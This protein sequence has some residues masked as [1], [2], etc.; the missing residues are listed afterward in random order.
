MGPHV[1]S[2]DDCPKPRTRGTHTPCPTHPQVLNVDGCI[3]ALFL[4]LLASSGC[5][6][7]KESAEIVQIGCGRPRRAG[8][9]AGAAA[10]RVAVRRACSHEWP[11]T[12][13]ACRAARGVRARL[14]LSAFPRPRRTTPSCVYR[15]CLSAIC[16]AGLQAASLVWPVVGTLTRF[17]W[18]RGPLGWWGMRWTR[19]ACSSRSTGTPG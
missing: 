6:S 8:R 2:V 3:G 10:E 17:S 1:L 4:D 15:L 12:A 5:F 11:G 7:D 14:A 18:W 9:R 19:S 13:V 16:I